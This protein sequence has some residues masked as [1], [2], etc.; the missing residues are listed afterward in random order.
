MDKKTQ[1]NFWY[2]LLAVLGVVLLRDI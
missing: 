2:I 1:V